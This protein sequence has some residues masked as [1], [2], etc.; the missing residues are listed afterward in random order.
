MKITQYAVHRRLATSAIV[1]ALTVLGFYG[2]WGLPV[3]YLPSV[4]YPMVKVTI[5]WRGAT[6]EEIEKNIAEILEREM[7]TVDRL[8]SLES[9]ATEG[10]YNLDVNF[11]YGADVDI[12]YQDAIAAVSRA[13]RQLPGDIEEPVI[14]KADPS[15]LPVMQLA[16]SSDQ[17]SMVE[18]RDWTERWLRD[19]LVAVPGVAGTNIVGGYEREIRIL[20]DPDALEKHM[21]PLNQVL[22][23]IAAENVDQFAGRIT[24]GRHEI[25]VRTSGEF[26]NLDE[27][28]RVVVARDGAA[29]VYLEDIATVEDSHEEVRVITRLNADNC[30]NIYVMKQADANTVEVA[31]AVQERLDAVEEQVPSGV[32][33]SVIENQALYVGSAINGVRNAALQ[34][35]ILLILVVY[36]FLGSIRQVIVMLLALPLTILFNFGL[37]RIAGFSLNVF[38]L[39]G[40]VVAIGIVLDN[41]IVVLES[42]TRRLYEQP[43]VDPSEHAIEGTNEVGSAIL[44]STLT[45]LALFLP[46]LLIPG[47]TSLLFRELILVMAGIVVIS[48][49]FAITL[50]PMFSATLFAHRRK[51]KGSSRFDRFFQRVSEGYDSLLGGVLRIRW[52]VLPAFAA[53]LV[54]AF[55]LIG[56]LGGEF[57]PPIDDGRISVKVRMPAGAS[58]GATDEVLQQIEDLI[59]EDPRIKSRFSL[60]GG[61]VRGLNTFEIAN[62]G[63][64]DIQLIPR[65]TRNISTSAYVTELRPKVNRIDIPGANLMP[66]QQR[67]RGIRGLSQSDIQVM[68]RGQDT[69]T[70][71]ALAEESTRLMEELGS[72][73]N[74][75]VSMDFSK[76][77]YQVRVDR[78]KAAELGI[79]V[80]DVAEGLRSLISGAV[81]TRFLDDGDYYDIRVLVPETALH[82]RLDVARLPLSNLSGE[83][84]RI[85][86]VAEVVQAVGPVEIVREDQIKQVIVQADTMG[87][88][89]AQARADLE[90]RLDEVDRPVGYDISFGGQA[91][92][93]EDMRSAVMGVLFFAVFF[94]FIVL[95]VQFNSWKF[96]GLILSGVP[97]SL[98]GVVFMLWLTGLPFGATVIIGLLVVIGATVNDGVL[99][100]MFAE[101]IRLR[102]DKSPVQA[103]L[104]AAR[105][106]LRPRLMTTLTTMAGFLPLALNL[107]EG[108]DMLQPMAM[109]AIGGLGMEMLVALFFM[110]CIYVV[111]SRKQHAEKAS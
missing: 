64:L 7:A 6:P 78:E 37:M 18:L 91:E 36:L 72:F 62:E 111:A 5:W 99:L 86:D 17:W 109:A 22:Q 38:S 43:D 3:D 66:Q 105:I 70:L 30:V 104:D 4:N 19:Q 95:A 83:F 40:L 25:I 54:V 42:I 97:L 21:L 49:T 76:P 26:Q 31:R 35:S 101:E 98:V 13:R 50:V 45:F 11:E 60:A 58:V 92:L 93:M 8:D 81:P 9:S 77:E 12:A 29:K 47:L 89:V 67:I 80:A 69:E 75:Y 102:D 84:L 100:I 33:F 74:V 63:Q 15:Q 10:M 106:R 51:K 41:A 52:L 1:L 28:R 87:A 55:L 85:S 16:V 107:E 44:A 46:F 48:L 14:F 110:P 39:G 65:A 2:L 82:S 73:S 34:A 71:F 24:A 20:L 94:A 27:I 56:R 79:S 88:S 59:A 23:R 90:A 108:G 61:V 32:R 68:I 53:L 57:L 96:P 103:V